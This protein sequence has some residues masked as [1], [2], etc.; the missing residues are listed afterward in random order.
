MA[1]GFVEPSRVRETFYRLREVAPRSLLPLFGYFEQQWLGSMPIDMW[2]VSDC[3][4]RTNNACEGWHNR[5]NRA[6]NRHHP[7]IWHLLRTVVD[8]QVS[9]DVLR[10][11]IAAGQSV[12]R[13]AAKYR[14]VRKNVET[15][16]NRYRAGTIDVMAFLDGISHNLKA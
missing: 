7:N 16:R 1:L 5:F 12:M 8:E 3:D 6:V 10:C 15:I 9:T 13:E 11:Q 14:S 4:L 2:N